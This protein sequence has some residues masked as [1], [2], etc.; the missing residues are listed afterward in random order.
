MTKLDQMVNNNFHGKPE[1]KCKLLLDEF[2][3]MVQSSRKLTGYNLSDKLLFQFLRSR[4]FN[5]QEALTILTNYLTIINERP[6]LF[7]WRDQLKEVANAGIYVHYPINNTNG[8]KIV[9]IKPGQWDPSKITFEQWFPQTLFFCEISLMDESVRENGIIGIIDMRN[10]YW[11][12]IYHIGVSGSRLASHITDY[13]FPWTIQSA[14]LVYENRLTSMAFN[15]FKPFLSSKLRQRINF[16]GSNL[17]TLYK[18]V[19]KSHL[20]PS[21]GGTNQEY[22]GEFYN[23]ILEQN[24]QTVLDHWQSLRQRKVSS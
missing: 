14:H 16:H 7:S 9:I 15:L 23:N 20:P 17:E 2:R 8:S 12:Q 24:K 18:F 3:E 22:S 10:L 13:C 4:D 1:K 19:P 6:D 5:Q 21:L 11:A